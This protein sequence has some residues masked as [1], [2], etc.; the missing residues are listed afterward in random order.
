MCKFALNE[1]G[2]DLL[3]FIYVKCCSRLGAAGLGWVLCNVLECARPF[4]SPRLRYCCFWYWYWYWFGI[5]V[6]IV[7]V[8]LFYFILHIT[9]LF[10]ICSLICLLI[11][12]FVVLSFVTLTRYM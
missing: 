10:V 4:S 2:V 11:C 7:I 1:M 6:V 3:I 9:C 5:V 12:S 8:V